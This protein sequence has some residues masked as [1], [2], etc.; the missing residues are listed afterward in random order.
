MGR[1]PCPARHRDGAS[2]SAWVREESWPDQHLLLTAERKLWRCVQTGGAPYLS[3]VDPPRPRVEAVRTVDM[4][5]SK[6]P[7]RV[8]RPIPTDTFCRP[9]RSHPEVLGQAWDCD[10]SDD[11][12]MLRS[13]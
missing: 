7:G 6:C 9:P 4:S 11:P 5:G 13:G 10:R 12:T 1:A 8:C 3:G 2:E